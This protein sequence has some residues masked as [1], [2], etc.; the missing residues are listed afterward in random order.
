MEAKLVV[1]KGSRQAQAIPLRG[2]EMIVGRQKGCGLRIPSAE[3][4]RRH[5]RLY[6]QDDYLTIEDLN[7]ANGCFLNGSRVRG[8]EILRPGDQLEIG[9]VTFQVEYQLTPRA[10]NAL[11]QPQS[12]LPADHEAPAPFD[13]L[14]QAI[15]P[16]D[17]LPELAAP[18][19]PADN[20][21]MFAFDAESGWQMP[22]GQ[23]LNAVLLEFDD[24][25]G[26]LATPAGEP[27]P[28]AAVPRSVPPQAPG[29]RTANDKADGI[30]NLSVDEG[31]QLPEGQNLN[32]ILSELDG[33]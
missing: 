6:F 14:P 28:P 30:P 26:T 16:E 3:V 15:L 10:I 13:E 19:G 24:S 29:P 27:A 7:S 22:E 9:P 31:W 33:R 20:E 32:D 12:R 21:V 2:P 17:P 18:A 11:L 23:D 4:S 8:V 1:V 25:A 5:A